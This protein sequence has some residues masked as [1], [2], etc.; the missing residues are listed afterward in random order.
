MSEY[1]LE[2][3]GDM[4]T[5]R[6]RF[7]AYARALRQSVRPGDVVLDIGTGTGIFALMAAR[8]GARHVYGVET[9]DAIQLGRECAAASGLDDV[10]TFFQGLSTDFHPPEPADV[11][12]SDLRGVLP[13]HGGHLSAIMDARRRLLKPGGTLI[14]L[15]DTIKTA[16]VSSSAI[17]DHMTAPWD[18][19]SLGLDLGPAR[20]LA[21]HRWR[22][23]IVGVGDLISDPAELFSLDYSRLDTP[24][25]GGNAVLDIARDATAHGLVVWFDALLADGI[26]LT[27][28]PGAPRLVYGHAFFPWPRPTVV[29]KGDRVE[30]ELRA[31]PVGGHYEWRWRSRV[32]SD[33]DT[34]RLVY[35]QSTLAGRAFSLDRL[36]RR[37]AHARPLLTPEGRALAMVLALF[38]G[39]RDLAGMAEALSERFPEQFP[40]RQGA[41]DFAA[42]AAVRFGH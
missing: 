20:R 4:I 35:D 18:G 34:P 3:Y 24:Q 38:D 13:L 10:T 31:D 40:T 6:V 28:A 9:S 19:R 42:E 2:A 8:L 1:S 14:P 27:T 41:L 25:A 17:Y 33:G 23:A 15:R 12:I 22:N 29:N 30:V 5:D 39:D 32:C 16:V 26:S 36:H 7:D 37:A 21:T 11:V